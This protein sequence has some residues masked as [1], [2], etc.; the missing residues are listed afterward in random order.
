MRTRM[1]GCNARWSRQGRRNH[2]TDTGWSKTRGKLVAGVIRI[3]R[4]RAF[5]QRAGLS[6]GNR[7]AISRSQRRAVC[8][9]FARTG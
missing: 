4:Y 9:A 1:L 7:P 8:A 3:V 5:G 6:S 2:P